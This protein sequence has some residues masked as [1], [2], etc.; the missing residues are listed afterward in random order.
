MAVAIITGSAGLVGSEAARYFAA[1]GFDIVGID[2]DMRR[3]FFGQEASTL[4]SRL[5]LERELGGSYRH[6]AIDIRDRRAV[7]RVFRTYGSDTLLVIH[8]AAQPSHDWAARD[9]RTDFGVNALGTLNLLEAASNTAPEATFIFTSTNKVY[10]DTPNRLP[11]VELEKRYEVHPEHPYARG[12]PE[13]MGV[14][15]CLH[16]LFGASKL[17]ADILVQEYGRQFGMRTVCFRAGCLT[18][19]NH[20][21]A[22]LHGFLSYLMKCTV[23]G[24]TYT[25]FGYKGKQVRD[26]LHAA[27]LVRAFDEFFR[28][29]RVAEVYNIG[30]GRYSNCSM[31]E[32]IEMCEQIASRPLNWRYCD[33]NR[34]GDHVW[35]ISDLSK[36]QSHYP[37]WRPRYDV[38]AILREI[39]A[40]NVEHWSAHVRART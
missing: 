16:S 20:R 28:A 13:Q 25:V 18:G 32:A 17:A 8:T 10:G 11:L 27:D 2:N 4:R 29:P 36:F 22:Q 26:N 3:S 9:P 23:T 38:Q 15:Q 34:K 21:G 6:Y 5:A 30:G 24:T 14:D 33:R 1:R 39:Y 7:Q 31:L 40:A 35:W 12:I 19:P 37:A